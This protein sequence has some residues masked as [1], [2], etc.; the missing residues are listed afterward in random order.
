MTDPATNKSRGFVFVTFK[1]PSTVTELLTGT[2]YHYV[3]G[4]KVTNSKRSEI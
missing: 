2:Q 4:K 3:D 1:N